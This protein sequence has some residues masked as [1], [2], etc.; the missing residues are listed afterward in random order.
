MQKLTNNQA[1]QLLAKSLGKYCMQICFNNGVA[2]SESQTWFEELTWA[3]P[4]LS[5][6]KDYQILIE[7]GGIL[8]FE[9]KGEMEKIFDVTVGDEGPTKN[10]SYD[11]PAK[12]YALTCSP[13]GELLT[14]NT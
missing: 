14:E 4:Y 13:D 10:N 6:D 5:Y 3:A 1:F 9:S 11:G 12:V 2:L 8:V 7:G